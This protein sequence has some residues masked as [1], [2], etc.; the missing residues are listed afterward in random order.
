M[1]WIG[2]AL[3]VIGYVTGLVTMWNATTDAREVRR[4]LTRLH[5]SLA[6]CLMG[7]GCIVVGLNT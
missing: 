2:G 4:V 5:L 7:L 1:I 6:A 3:I